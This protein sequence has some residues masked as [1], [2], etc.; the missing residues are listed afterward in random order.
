MSSEVLVKKSADICSAAN[1]KEKKLRLVN[2]GERISL[3]VAFRCISDDAKV[4]FGLEQVIHA[5]FR[6][7][8]PKPSVGSKEEKCENKNGFENRMNSRYPSSLH[9]VIL[10]SMSWTAIRHHVHVIPTLI[11]CMSRWPGLKNTK[12]WMSI[13]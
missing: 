7:I 13:H 11:L 2:V 10:C 1:T 12:Q 5:G 8:E 3:P 4:A 6:K 9:E